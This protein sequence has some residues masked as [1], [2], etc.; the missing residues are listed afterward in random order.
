MTDNVDPA[1]IDAINLLVTERMLREVE[2]KNLD[3]K[4]EADIA[5]LTAA[6]AAE[7][8]VLEVDIQSLDAGIRGI[9]TNNESTLLQSGKRSFTTVIA[10]FQF[11]KIK[12]RLDITDT[13]LVMDVARKLGVVR[14]IAKL[15]IKWTF[16]ATKFK[17]WL[18]K[19]GEY[20]NAFADGIEDIAAYESLTIKPNSTHVVHYD[21]KRISPPSITIH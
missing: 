2:V 6:H 20:R 4:L 8:S 5:A 14:K 16:S 1:L 7:R 18:A 9:I 12:E 17:D 13:K 19:N 15:S 21:G 10:A 3:A 11:S